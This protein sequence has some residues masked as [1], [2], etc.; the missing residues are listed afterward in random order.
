[1]IFKF[2]R[3]FFYHGA[4]LIYSLPTDCL[5]SALE[6]TLFRVLNSLLF[7]YFAYLIELV[8]L[9]LERSPRPVSLRAKESLRFESGSTQRFLSQHHLT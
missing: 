9:G 4:T 8:N 3:L 7:D 6:T 1:M 5:A 2:L